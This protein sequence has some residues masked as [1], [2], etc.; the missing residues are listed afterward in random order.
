MWN[1]YDLKCPSSDFCEYSTLDRS[2]I[3][4]LQNFVSVL[5]AAAA[6]LT[7]ESPVLKEMKNL[8]DVQK[9]YNRMLCC[10]KCLK[11]LQRIGHCLKHMVLLNLSKSYLDLAERFLCGFRNYT[12]F[13]NLPSKQQLEYV[14][15]RTKTAAKLISEA[16]TYSQNTFCFLLQ[17]LK[18]KHLVPELMLSTC[19]T[20]KFNLMLKDTLKQLCTMYKEV[21]PWRTKLLNGMFKWPEKIDLPGDLEVWLETFDT[22]LMKSPSMSKVDFDILSSALNVKLNNGNDLDNSRIDESNGISVISSCSRKKRK[23]LKQSKMK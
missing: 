7:E 22:K 2:E 14:L 8:H 20:A 12:V 11:I 10:D 4:N 3:D 6:S 5:S 23:I 15:V 21:L 17:K 13:L 1:C 9:R 19:V 18:M 16:V